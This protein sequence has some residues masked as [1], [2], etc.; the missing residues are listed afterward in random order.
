MFSDADIQRVMELGYKKHVAV[1]A[2]E[3]CC[4]DVN[5]ACDMLLE[6]GLV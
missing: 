2:L 4:G 5:K 6:C 1:Y 3:A